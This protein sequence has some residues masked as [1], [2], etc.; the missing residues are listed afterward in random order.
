MAKTNDDSN[1]FKN[2]KHVPCNPKKVPLIYS[3]PLRWIKG[4]SFQ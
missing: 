3:G 2:I 4:D 1:V